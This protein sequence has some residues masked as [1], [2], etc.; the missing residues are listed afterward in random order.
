MKYG[1]IISQPKRPPLWSRGNI[2]TSHAGSPGSINGRVNFLVEIFSRVFPLNRKRNL[3]TFR[4]HSS[5]VIIYLP[6]RLVHN[7]VAILFR[8]WYFGSYGFIYVLSVL[9]EVQLICLSLRIEVLSFEDSE[10]SRGG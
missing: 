1:N 9:F 3:R 4:P 2:V 6:K 10:W 5:P 7:S 8:C